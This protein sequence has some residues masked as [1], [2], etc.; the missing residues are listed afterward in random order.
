MEVKITRL[1][2][3]LDETIKYF[4]EKAEG[5]DKDR[6]FADRDIRHILDKSINDIILCLVDISEEVLKRHRRNIP[7]TYKDTVLACYEFVGDSTLKVAPLTKHR[8]EVV[9]QYLKINWQNILTV[10][11]RVPEIRDFAGRIRR[12]FTKE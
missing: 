10:K 6:Y 8:N 4:L 11:N 9:H 3:F 7:D 12:S 2:S 5:V 1:L